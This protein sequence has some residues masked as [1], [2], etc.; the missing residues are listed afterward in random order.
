MGEHK[1]NLS[2]ETRAKIRA[3][4]NRINKEPRSMPP[5]L[6]LAPAQKR[7]DNRKRRK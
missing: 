6:Y 4:L 5:S 1:L 3:R 2:E 7:Q